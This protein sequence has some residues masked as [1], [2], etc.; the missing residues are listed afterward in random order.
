MSQAW[1]AAKP[2]H[3][4]FASHTLVSALHLQAEDDQQED[5]PSLG[6][7]AAKLYLYLGEL[8]FAKLDMCAPVLGAPGRL[9]ACTSTPP[10]GHAFCLE[11]SK[12][13]LARSWQREPDC[14]ANSWQ[15]RGLPVWQG[16]QVCAPPGAC[17]QAT[18]AGHQRCRLPGTQPSRQNGIP[19]CV[20]S[21]WH[22]ASTPRHTLLLRPAGKLAEVLRVSDTFLEAWSKTGFATTFL[23]NRQNAQDLAAFFLSLDCC[24]QGM[25]LA[26]VQLQ[27]RDG[28]PF[29]V[30]KQQA[31]STRWLSAGMHPTVAGCN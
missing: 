16:T 21:C 19:S 29:K 17:M 18:D 28:R 9:T 26:T 20:P 14:W 23:S 6:L 31:V 30:G 12:G 7:F 5:A 10:G 8:K 22:A 2:C 15:R 3:S 11:A 13:V 1:V 27:G 24:L 25:V 4:S